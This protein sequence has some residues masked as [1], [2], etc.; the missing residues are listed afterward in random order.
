[1]AFTEEQLASEEWRSVVGWEG[2]YEVSSLGQVR[3]IP[4]TIVTKSGVKAHLE[5]RYL[6]LKPN[7]RGYVMVSLSRDGRGTT[8]QVHRIVANAFIPNVNGLQEIDHVNGVRNDNRVSNLRWSSRIDNC[9]N[10]VFDGCRQTVEPY[11]APQINIDDLPGEKWRDINGY[12]GLY[13]ISSLGRVKS[14]PR[15]RSRGG[16]LRQTFSGSGYLGVCLC[17]NGK[18]RSTQVHRLVAIHFIDNP[19]NLPE[20]NHKDEDKTNNEASNLEWATREY[21]ENYGTAHERGT[22]NHDYAKSSI[23]SAANH[24]YKA[25]G[26]KRRKPVMQFGLGGELIQKWSGA[27]EIEEAL[28]FASSA[29]SRA[30]NKCGQYK[31]GVAYGYYW[32][33]EEDFQCAS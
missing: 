5:G 28:G 15:Q 21:N 14:I 3:S 8:T 13:Q 24:D 4:R 25:I 10:R 31:T 2:T 30:C 26:L 18:R 1:M 22:R 9:K 17:K 6:S 12:E 27:C 19:D 23:K 16:I 7:E 20:V 33:F 11:I 32:E 29:I